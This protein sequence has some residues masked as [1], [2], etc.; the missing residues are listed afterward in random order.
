MKT[1]QHSQRSSN[2][3]ELPVVQEN[4]AVTVE[5]E[6]GTQTASRSRSSIIPAKLPAHSR[7]ATSQRLND[8][9]LEPVHGVYYEV[10]HHK[11]HPQGWHVKRHFKRK[12]LRLSNLRYLEADQKGTKWGLMPIALGM[13]AIIMVLSAGLITFTAISS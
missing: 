6:G 7:A 11:E 8:I 3:A 4:T 1:E 13:L 12:N 2:T 10:T 5:G 9:P